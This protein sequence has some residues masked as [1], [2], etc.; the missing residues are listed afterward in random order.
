MLLLPHQDLYHG[1]DGG[2]GDDWVRKLDSLLYGREP[3]RQLGDGLPWQVP[4]DLD[5]RHRADIIALLVG[6][7]VGDGPDVRAKTHEEQLQVLEDLN[8]PILLILLLLLQ[9]LL[10]L[11]SLRRQLMIPSL[12][13]VF[14]IHSLP[15]LLVVPLHAVPPRYQVIY[16]KHCVFQEDLLV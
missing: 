14:L 7:D 11:H 15:L 8:V 4:L 9:L 16:Q 12:L 1:L 2:Q 10:V 13:E 6:L 5:D 3:L